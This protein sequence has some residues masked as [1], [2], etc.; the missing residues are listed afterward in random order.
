MYG[1]KGAKIVVAMLSS[2]VRIKR[3]TMLVV[4]FVL[5]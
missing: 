1:T 4:F 3:R 5:D 2:S